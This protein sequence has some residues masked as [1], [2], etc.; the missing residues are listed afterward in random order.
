[1][2][3]KPKVA[4]FDFTSCEGCQLTVVDALQTHLGLLDLIEIVEFREAMSE[5]SDDYQI[6]FVEGSCTRASDE[7]RLRK[8]RKQAALV[9]ALGACAHLGGVNAMKNRW[10]IEE[11]QTYVY[12]ESGKEYYESYMARPISAV[13]DVDVSIPG[14]PIDRL[15]FVRVV[16]QLLQGCTPKLPDYS[17]CVECKLSENACLN[18][19][20]KP[21]LGPIT[22]A[23]CNALCI[24][25]GDGCEGCRGF[26]PE[27]NLDYMRQILEEQ[28]LPAEI[29]DAKFT[30]FNAYALQEMGG[31]A[32]LAG[33]GSPNGSRRR[34]RK[35]NWPRSTFASPEEA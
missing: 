10:P 13:I 3:A 27:A 11:V 14:C 2:S 12:G 28:N 16:Q 31:D 24:S 25:Y 15:E 5:H 32:P 33:N 30:L 8:I 1:M 18:K 34:S 35:Q 21:C 6:A 29:I 7:E 26:A 19:L 17:L 9:V 22:R 23:G 4:F 20:G